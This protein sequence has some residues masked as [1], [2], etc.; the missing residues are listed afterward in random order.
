MSSQEDRV[1]QSISANNSF[2]TSIS[3]THEEVHEL[4]DANNSLKAPEVIAAIKKWSRGTKVTA[5]QAT[6]LDRMLDR[7][8]AIFASTHS[9]TD[10]V[11]R[12]QALDEKI[13]APPEAKKTTYASVARSTPEVRAPKRPTRA[14][15]VTIKIARQSVA[16]TRAQ[17]SG[18]EVKGWVEKALK[19]TGVDGLREME[20]QGVQ[21]HRSGTKVTIRLKSPVDAKAIVRSATKCSKALG[22]GAKVSVPHF[23]VVVQ[24]VPL[25]YDPTSEDT[26]REL[27]TQN[28]HL[29]PSPEAIVDI[30]WLVP[31]DKLPQGRRAGSWVV[32]LD[33]RQA[34]DNL[35]DQSVKVQSLLLTA[36]RYFT[37]PRQ[38]RKCQQWG[39]LSYSCTAKEQTCAHCGRPHDSQTCQTK[40]SKRCVNCNGNH[41]SFYPQCPIRRTETLRARMAQAGESVYFAG[42]DFQFVSFLSSSP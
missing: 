30:R 5:K 34:A 18:E 16:E 19:D 8:L 10:I 24:G 38:C 23:G 13:S 25:Y 22:E 33:N 1:A 39:H 2:E 41:D 31:K 37:G 26:R 4:L 21:P 35:I 42:I 17:G 27:H 40:D 11:E 20:V 12:L 7:L 29:L 6:A 15:E 9:L 14:D 32:F 28:P 3:L 36:R